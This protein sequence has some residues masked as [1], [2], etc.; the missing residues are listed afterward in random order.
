MLRR[1]LTANEKHPVYDCVNLSSPIQ[2]QLSLKPTNFS[3]SFVLFLDPTS[4]FKHFQKQ[5]DPLPTFFRKLQNMK[6]LV[7]PLYQKH[8]SR[9]PFDNQHVKG[10]QT[11][12]KSA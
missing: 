1:T 4:N 3:R 2:M 5:G 6:N 9:T 7:R 8:R 12:I 10:S 11:L